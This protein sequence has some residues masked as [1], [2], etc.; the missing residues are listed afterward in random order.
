MPNPQKSKIKLKSATLAL[1]GY[2]SH[3]QSK[4]ATCTQLA[5]GKNI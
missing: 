2:V 1:A 3:F 5:K 4:L